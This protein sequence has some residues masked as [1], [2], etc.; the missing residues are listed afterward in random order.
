MHPSIPW[1]R[2]K[3]P[4]LKMTEEG[5]KTVSFKFG[6]A[7]AEK[8]KKGG[9]VPNT[10]PSPLFFWSSEGTDH[11][12]SFDPRV[13]GQTGVPDTNGSWVPGNRSEGERVLGPTPRVLL[14]AAP[15]P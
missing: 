14:D 6:I 12:P 11:F 8:K 13:G 1:G 3:A 9:A 15:G 2:E 4:M 10:G 5:P 7:V